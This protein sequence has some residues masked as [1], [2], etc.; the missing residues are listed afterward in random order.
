M[1]HFDVRYFSRGQGQS[2]VAAAA[3]RSGQKLYDRY[4]GEIH[5]FTI[6]GGVVHTWILLPPNAPPEY[7]DREMLW[8][9]VEF[10]EDVS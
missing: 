1:F 8:N 3:Y 6:K 10:R 5:D 7:A 9:A 4:Y 2:I